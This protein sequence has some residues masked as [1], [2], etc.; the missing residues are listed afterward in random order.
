MKKFINYLIVPTIIATAIT[1]LFGLII[2][3][4]YHPDVFDKYQI[5][6]YCFGL[7]L[8]LLNVF[9]FARWFIFDQPQ[10]KKKAQTFDEHEE[11]LH[12]ERLLRDYITFHA[13]NKVYVSRKMYTYFF[14]TLTFAR[15][16]PDYHYERSRMCKFIIDPYLK[17]FEFGQ[18]PKNL[19][20]NDFD[21]LL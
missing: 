13:L 8:T 20:I 17:N 12:K 15:I 1:L 6:A 14:K 7:E 19:I 10:L 4:R 2:V 16:A 11:Y 9:M 5:T 21:D 18:S 3:F